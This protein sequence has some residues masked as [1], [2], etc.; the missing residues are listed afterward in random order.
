[1]L[2]HGAQ[3]LVVAHRGAS[4]IAP[5]NSLEAFAKAIEIGADMVEFDVRRTA[6]RRLIAFHDEL[7]EGRPICEWS[8]DELAAALGHPPPRLDEIVYLCAG[9]IRL[10]VELKERGTE[11]ETLGLVTSRF[12]RDE[13]VVTSFLVEVV[14]AVKR[15]IRRGSTVRVR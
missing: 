12:W 15:V 1:M 6:D 11:D 13:F 3:P 10:D 2:R 4:R 9:R 8:F 5:E 14:A 7:V